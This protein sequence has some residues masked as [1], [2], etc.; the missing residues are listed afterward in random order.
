MDV[1]KGDYKTTLEQFK[2]V[3]RRSENDVLLPSFIEMMET[4][5]TL[6][7]N[8]QAL[9]AAAVKG[10][11]SKRGD[12]AKL[13]GEYRKVLQGV[14]DT[15]DAITG[16]LTT[17]GA[18]LAQIAKGEIPEKI[19]DSYQGDF[20][21]LKLNLNQCIETQDGVAHVAGQIAEGDLTVQAKALSEGYPRSG[22]SPRC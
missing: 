8:T 6:V 10:D 5:D 21:V 14:N 22:A 4:I 12:V 17:A 20:N 18:R 1:A 13:R 16:P 15:L 3:G 7:H 11:L 19:A 9:S 2:K